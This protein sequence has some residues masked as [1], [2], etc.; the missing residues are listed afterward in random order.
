MVW[1]CKGIS[2]HPLQ[3]TLFNHWLTDFIKEHKVCWFARHAIYIQK[4][5][6]C[7]IVCSV[8]DYHRFIDCKTSLIEPNFS[9][10]ITHCAFSFFQDCSNPQKNKK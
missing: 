9:V 5:N 1:G 8:D 2:R 7:D 3:Q 10:V 6:V 4:T